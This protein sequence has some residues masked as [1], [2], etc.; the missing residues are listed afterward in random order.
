MGSAESGV[1]PAARRSL[2]SSARAG[3]ASRTPFL[4]ARWRVAG[5]PRTGDDEGGG[6]GRAGGTP[7]S[8][9]PAQSRPATS[10]LL[11]SSSLAFALRSSTP[12]TANTPAL[13]YPPLSSSSTLLWSVVA[14]SCSPCTCAW[15]AHSFSL[16]Q[17]QLSVR[18]WV[19]GDCG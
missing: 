1:P 9:R 10:S 8:R 11:F 6:Q 2:P 18:A 13:S 19:R 3:S 14:A 15:T 12:S 16:A 17:R 7:V 4:A 5:R